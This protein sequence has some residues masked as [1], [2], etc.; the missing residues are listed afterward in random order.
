MKNIKIKTGSTLLVLLLSVVVLVNCNKKEDNNIKNINSVIE[1]SIAL[2]SVHYKVSCEGVKSCVDGYD[3][4]SI[5]CGLV[6]AGG[7]LGKSGS[8]MECTCSS[9]SMIVVISD[10]NGNLKP[11]APINNIPSVEFLNDFYSFCLDKYSVNKLDIK[12]IE[13]HLEDDVSVEIYEYINVDG[14]I[15]TIAISQIGNGNDV[16]DKVKIDC[17]SKCTDGTDDC[18]E[19]WVFSSKSVE[20]TCTGC[21]MEVTEL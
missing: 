4:N 21:S 11:D 15:E 5:V 1:S 8:G 14:A 13:K 3:P 2:K 16:S 17:T 19:R 20:C 18:R 12:S 7:P 10:E 6:G 9:C